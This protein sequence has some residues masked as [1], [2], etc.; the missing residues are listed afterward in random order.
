MRIA[1]FSVMKK[2]ADSGYRTLL[3][4]GKRPDTAS[5]EAPHHGIFQ[6][7]PLVASNE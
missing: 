4:Q 5:R 7:G 3:I 6:A 1:G 2:L